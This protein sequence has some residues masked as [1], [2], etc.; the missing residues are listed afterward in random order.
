MGADVEREHESWTVLT[1]TLLRDYA[2]FIV[3]GLV[4]AMAVAML[5]G[6]LAGVRRPVEACR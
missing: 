5:L 6:V 1:L 3:S 2:R 4:S